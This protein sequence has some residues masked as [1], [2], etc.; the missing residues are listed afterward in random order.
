MFTWRISDVKKTKYFFFVFDAY[1]IFLFYNTI[2]LS[3][4]HTKLSV[5][6]LPW[7]CSDVPEKISP[8]RDEKETSDIWFNF[9][10]ELCFL[11]LLLLSSASVTY[12]AYVQ[13]KSFNEI[14]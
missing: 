1:T 10:E 4:K 2:L 14:E 3:K 5:T 9:V 8:E 11:V 7:N 12:A 13:W 6:Q